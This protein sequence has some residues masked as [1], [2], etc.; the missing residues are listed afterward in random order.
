V[1]KESP[2]QRAE[3]LARL[4]AAKSKTSRPNSAGKV[5]G[6]PPKKER[7]KFKRGAGPPLKRRKDGTY[8]VV[9]KILTRDPDLVTEVPESPW[10]V[11]GHFCLVV[12]KHFPGANLPS[13][14]QSKYLGWAKRM[15]RDFSRG[16]L[17]EM[18]QVFVMDFNNLNSARIFYKLSGTP[19]PT[20]DQFYSNT[21]LWHSFIGKG[22]IKPPGARYSSYLDAYN[23]RHGK[24][25][26]ISNGEASQGRTDVDPIE[27]LRDQYN[28]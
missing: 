28:A 4:K 18:I 21:S 11:Y 17:Y 3:R 24:K 16:E 12:R 5:E 27:A 14:G 15:L 1:A 19:T 9:E 7:T 8:E 6:P 13:E 22:I 20:F 10:G 23:K 25:N 26:D 2:E